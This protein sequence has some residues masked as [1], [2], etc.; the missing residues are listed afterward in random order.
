MLLTHIPSIVSGASPLVSTGVVHYPKGGLASPFGRKAKKKLKGGECD[1]SPEKGENTLRW[2]NEYGPVI[3]GGEQSMDEK[4]SA[5]ADI[6][7][8]DQLVD[9]D[10]EETAEWHQ[11]LDAAL[12]TGGPVRARYL[13]LSLLQH[14]HEKSI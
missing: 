13:L 2:S 6:Q 14:A 10:P 5:A 9:I 7:L 1:L 8:I 11:S 3:K 4:V 12:E